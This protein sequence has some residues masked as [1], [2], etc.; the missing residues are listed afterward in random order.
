M[1]SSS[2]HK[3]KLDEAV[4]RHVEELTVKVE[5]PVVRPMNLVF[6]ADWY[7]DQGATQ[8]CFEPEVFAD[9]VGD[10]TARSYR[11]AGVPTRNNL[12]LFNT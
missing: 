6:A 4:G 11:V 3:K 9:G 5:G 2:Y 1:I 7:R 12:R 10:V 8:R